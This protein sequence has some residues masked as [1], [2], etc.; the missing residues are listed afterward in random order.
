VTIADV[1]RGTV[2]AALATAACGE[3]TIHL[4]G[5]DGGPSDGSATPGYRAAILTDAPLAYW[6]FGEQS[7]TIAND[8][9]GNGNAAVIG[10]GVTWNAPGALLDDTNTAVHLSGTQGLEVANQF[11]F[12]GNDRYSLE[13]WVYPET[14]FD[15]NYRHMFYKDDVTQPATGREEYGVYLQATDGL[16]FERYVMGTAT[17]VHAALPALKQWAYVVATYDGA[18]LTLYVNG[19]NVGTAVDTRPQASKTAPEYLGCKTFE[20]VSVQGTLDEF[21]IY[22]YPLSPA[23]VAAHWKASGR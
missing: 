10:A 11:D 6:R 15:G 21:A 8:E 18:H 9:T 23:Q 3:V 14:A 2:I 22:D 4:L 17:K 13:G 5:Q 16:V 1:R 12:P 7:G 20:S 19:S